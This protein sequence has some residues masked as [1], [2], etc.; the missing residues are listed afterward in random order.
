MSDQETL[1][2]A[3]HKPLLT[4][5]AH[6]TRASEGRIKK[7]F[8]SLCSL[9]LAACILGASSLVQESAA[10]SPQY[11]NLPSETPAKFK[12]TND[13]FE[14]DRRDVMIPMR[15]G[16]KLH[17]VI[18]V[19]KGAKGAPI[20]LTRTPYNA[21]GLTTHAQS[22]HLGPILNGYDNATEVIIEGGYIR[23]VQDVRGKYGSEGDYVMNRP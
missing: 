4:L 19:P 7:A 16:V 14:Y 21:T 3:Y 12:P 15:D 17:T 9:A 11:P 1:M 20:L 18:L 2:K 13:G 8:N 23:V 10:Q 5:E 6:I 22:S